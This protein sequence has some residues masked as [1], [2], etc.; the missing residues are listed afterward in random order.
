MPLR[1]PSAL[2]GPSLDLT[3]HAQRKHPDLAPN[4]SARFKYFVIPVRTY[5]LFADLADNTRFF[6]GLLRSGTVRR[7]SDIS[8]YV[9][10]L[11]ARYAHGS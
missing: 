1:L 6:K 10:M 2:F 4:S 8:G 11:P 7:R 5:C 3:C 9:G